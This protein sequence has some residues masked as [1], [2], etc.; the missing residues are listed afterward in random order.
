M[1]YNMFDNNTWFNY[2]SR[3]AQSDSWSSKPSKK[4]Q[5]NNKRWKYAI[6]DVVLC[7]EDKT[8]GVITDAYIGQLDL[9]YYTVSCF[10]IPSKNPCETDIIGIDELPTTPITSDHITEHATEHVTTPNRNMD[11]DEYNSWESIKTTQDVVDRLANQANDT[12]SRI[13]E[14]TGEVN[15][16]RNEL[17]DIKSEVVKCNHYVDGDFRDDKV[18]DIE[19]RVTD[20]EQKHK[21]SSKLAKLAIISRLL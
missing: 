8:I 11:L 14:L 17:S 21:K 3:E 6:D 20:I 2:T 15:I 16:Y 7:L 5:Q 9:P 13:D 12:T 18:G 1:Y 19:C 4:K 10:G